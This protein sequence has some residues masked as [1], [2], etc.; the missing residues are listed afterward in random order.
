MFNFATAHSKGADLDL[1]PF[2]MSS[3]LLSHRKGEQCLS[4]KS[5]R[6]KMHL[7]FFHEALTQRGHKFCLSR[8]LSAPDDGEDLTAVW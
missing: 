5:K 8:C 7:C 4:V 6:L 3:L 2:V 1:G